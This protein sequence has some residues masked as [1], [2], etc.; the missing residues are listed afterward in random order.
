MIIYVSGL[1]L[2]RSERGDRKVKPLLIRI[3]DEDYEELHKV[4]SHHGEISYIIR[5]SIKEFL[6][7]K[8]LE[9]E[10]KKK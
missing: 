10:G 3:P 2:I 5:K 1:R 4:I 7:V 8:R 6:R 9:K